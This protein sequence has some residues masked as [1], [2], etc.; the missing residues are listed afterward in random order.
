MDMGMDVEEGDVEGELEGSGEYL[1]RDGWAG[2]RVLL[3]RGAVR[4][5]VLGD[6]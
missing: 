6:I 5:D 3:A 4:A 1:P 2:P